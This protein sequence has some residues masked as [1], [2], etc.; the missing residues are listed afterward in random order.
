MQEG[1]LFNTRWR[2]RKFGTIVPA[3][4]ERFIRTLNPI[5]S[6]FPFCERLMP[7]H[8]EELLKQLL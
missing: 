5:R 2:Y 7:A 1:R 6:V 3:V 8:Q 4:N